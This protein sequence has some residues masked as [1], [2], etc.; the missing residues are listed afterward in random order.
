MSRPP[1]AT[2]RQ[3]GPEVLVVAQ[4]TQPKVQTPVVVATTIVPGAT[5]T[6]VTPTY[7]PPSMTVKELRLMAAEKGIAD[8]AIEHARDADD[9]TAELLALIQAHDNAPTPAPIDFGS[10]TVRELREMASTAGV[11]HEAI[12]VARDGNDPR[13]ELIALI[14]AHN[15]T[16]RWP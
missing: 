4:P 5:N 15:A 8:D 10:K 6:D 13:N 1:Q 12:E 16:K 9:P 7:A 11:A 14:A 3:P 2:Q